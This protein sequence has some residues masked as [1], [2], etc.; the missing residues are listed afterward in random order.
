MYVLCSR[1]VLEL[2][3]LDCVHGL[4][5][6]QVLDNRRCD[7]LGYVHALRSREVLASTRCEQL[8]R[9]PKRDHLAR[10]Q[11]R[12]REL[13]LRR[14]VRASVIY[15]VSTASKRAA[16]TVARFQVRLPKVALVFG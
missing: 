2:D 6:R 12:G 7:R 10:G 4:S 14:G 8:S 15:F 9:V 1:H 11:Q 5:I 3:R 13:R 16:S